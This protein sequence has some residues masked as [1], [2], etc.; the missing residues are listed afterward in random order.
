[1]KSRGLECHGIDFSK[2]AVR[3]AKKKTKSQ[4]LLGD[5]EKLP[6]ADNCFDYVTALGALEHFEHVHDGIRE[7]VR[8]SKD[9]AKFLITVPNF[10]YLF[11]LFRKE[12]GTVQR[13]IYE[14]LFTLDGWKTVLEHNGLVIDMV[15]QDTYF[16][17]LAHTRSLFVKNPLS[18]VEGIIKK[19]V[20][21][22][23]PTAL[24][25]LFVFI[26]SKRSIRECVAARHR[27]A[28][29]FSQGIGE[30]KLQEMR[31]PLVKETP[32]S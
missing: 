28:E 19:I 14:H 6:Y 5:G 9:S 10:N 7:I 23:M 15:F 17:Y 8:V 4:I 11:Y 20:W 30:K 22:F 3:V 29:P 2:E 1:M 13:E 21:L 16:S 12:R 31:T 32:V 24:T 26:C 27:I 18:F 25:Y